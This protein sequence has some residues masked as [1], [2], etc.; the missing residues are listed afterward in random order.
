MG[1]TE[2]GGDPSRNIRVP[3]SYE[4][5]RDAFDLTASKRWGRWEAKLAVRDLLNQNILFKQFQTVDGNKIQQVTR[6]Y[7]PGRNINLSVTVTL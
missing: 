5:P 2:G 1:R 4:M 6:K 7:K 3:D